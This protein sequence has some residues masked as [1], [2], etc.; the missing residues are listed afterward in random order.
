M[1]KAPKIEPAHQF[2]MW[3]GLE[4]DCER[5]NRLIASEVFNPIDRKHVYFWSAL[6]EI[7]IHTRNLAYHAEKRW[8]SRLT[9]RDDLVPWVMYEDITEMIVFFRDALCHS[10]ANKIMT[11][12]G[13]ASWIK[14]VIVGK[15]EALVSGDER[16][17]SAFADDALIL[18]GMGRSYLKRH[19]FRAFRELAALRASKDPLQCILE[20]LEQQER[21]PPSNY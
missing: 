15:Q 13:Q 18:A 19:I 3:G 20:R 17:I 12:G 21:E 2:F 8:G 11:D 9:W 16:I 14:G 1:G 6:T 10:T 5:A 7:L 4:H